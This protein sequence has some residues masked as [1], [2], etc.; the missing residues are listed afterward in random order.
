MQP[1]PVID[2]LDT[3][4]MSMWYDRKR[5]RFYGIFH[6]HQYIGLVSSADGTN[7]EKAKNFVVLTKELSF[8][9]GETIKPNRMERPFVHIEDGEPKTLCLAIKKGDES[10]TVFLPIR[11]EK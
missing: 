8:K 2:Y 4:D 9:E 6:A 1:K 7:W 3:E 10:Y 5:G 11:S